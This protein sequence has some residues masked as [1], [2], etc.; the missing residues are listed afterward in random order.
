MWKRKFVFERRIIWRFTRSQALA[1]TATS[2]C[3]V[4]MWMWNYK[5]LLF[6]VVQNDEIKEEKKEWIE[7]GRFTLMSKRVDLFF[8]WV[9]VG[10]SQPLNLRA[11]RETTE[12]IS[13]FSNSFYFFCF[14]IVE[15]FWRCC[16]RVCAMSR[17][18]CVCADIAYSLISNSSPS[19]HNI[20][21]AKLVDHRFCATTADD[22][23]WSGRKFMIRL[24]ESVVIHHMEN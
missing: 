15:F 13:S 4:M 2:A 5:S 12:I 6:Y 10:Y 22:D 11:S 8:F 19:S 23:E 3:V 21:P 20:D 18:P 17:P 16:L 7:R 9:S 14:T 1:Y 24:I